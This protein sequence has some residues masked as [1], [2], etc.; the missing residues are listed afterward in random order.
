M[1]ISSINSGA[2]NP[3]LDQNTKQTDNG[4]QANSTTTASTGSA[5]Q[6]NLDSG[7]NSKT[8]TFS[9]TDKQS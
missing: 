5:N 8:N 2:G 9:S 1:A 4:K 3:Y 6:A 7:D